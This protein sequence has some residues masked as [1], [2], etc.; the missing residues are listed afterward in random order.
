MRRIYADHNATTPLAPEVLG[1]ML[2]YLREHFGNASSVHIFGR[3]CRAAI[4]ERNSSQP[5]I[6]AV[7]GVRQE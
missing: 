4:G 2:P 6:P 3:E 5:R 7:P 1:A